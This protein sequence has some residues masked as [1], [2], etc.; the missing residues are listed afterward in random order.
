MPIDRRYRA[1]VVGQ[2][3]VTALMKPGSQSGF[4]DAGWSGKNNDFT[5]H[6]N[7]AGVEYQDV[8]LAEQRTHG[9]PH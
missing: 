4:T 5:V 1:Q 3:L 8:S 7:G 2:K 6:L 9:R